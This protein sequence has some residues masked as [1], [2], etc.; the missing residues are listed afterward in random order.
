MTPPLRFCFGLHLHQPVGNFDH[1]FQQHLDEVYRPL[2][3]ALVGGEAT[4]VAFHVSGPLLEWLEQH[5]GAFVDELGVHVQDGRVELLCAG[6]DEPILAVLPVADRVEQIA[7]HREHLQRRFGVAVHGLWLTERVWEPDLPVALAEAGVTFALVDDR[8]FLVSG[9]DRGQL[10]RPFRTEAGGRSISLFPIDERMRYLIPFRPTSELIEHFRT[11]RAQGASLAI[12][13]DDGEKFGGWPGTADWLYR[14][15]WL[16]DFLA[17]LRHLRDAGEVVLSRF[18]EALAATPS[19]GLAYLPSAS[20]REMEGWA[21]PADAARRLRSVEQEWGSARLDGAEGSL[22][23]GGHWRHFLVKY[24]ESNRLHKTMLRLS[25]LSRE[26]GDPA[27]VRRHIGRAQ[28]N[29]AYWHGVFGGL[30]LPFLRRALWD[31]LAIAESLLRTDEAATLTMLDYDCDGTDELLLT[32]AAWS[33]TIAPARGGAVEVWLDLRHPRN[34]IDTLTRHREA[35]HDAPSEDVAGTPAHS[36]DGG[37]AS[38]HD[39]ENAVVSRPPIDADIRSLLIDRLIDPAA[40]ADDFQAGTIPTLRSW[41]AVPFEP[42]WEVAG[43][44]ARVTLSAPD[45]VRTLHL[46]ED[47]ALTCEWSWTTDHDHAWF[48]TELSLSVPCRIDAP[49]A[50]TWEYPI[51]TVARSERGFDR[52]RQ[53]QAIVLR[54]P[55]SARRAVAVLTPLP[56]GAA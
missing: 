40:T 17:T 4:P 10:H 53:G 16:E 54:W 35:Y 51:E 18:D 52:T 2:L 12:L 31:E 24:P 34:L 37:T 7:R 56:P 46:A 45:L 14:Q 55:A 28:C 47:G 26:R 11:Q 19:G 25:A 42:T 20:Y 43:S 5:A 50:L 15:G 1:V 44:R 39:L 3:R 48:T 29:D 30:Y 36:E 6:H 9:F 32:S 38:I 27:T 8:H 41:A 21:L 23:R 49:G 33:L 13:A 22:L